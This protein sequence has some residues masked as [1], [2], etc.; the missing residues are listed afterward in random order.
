MKTLLR[1]LKSFWFLILA[2]WAASLVVC[3][4]VAPRV[5]W[6]REQLLETMLIVSTFY[7]LIIVLRQYKRI[8][9]ERNLENLVQIEVDR[10]LKSNGEFRDQQ[11]L[12]DRLKHAIAMLRADRS[13]GG[14]GSSALYDLPWYLVIGMSAAGKTSLLTRSGLSASIAS[15]QNDNDS[16][17]QHCDWYFSP[18]A[19]LIDTAGRYL[20][21]DQSA[22]EFT[23]FLQLL[24]KQRKKAAVNGLVLVVSLP[25]L[26]AAT[27]D[28]RAQM[29][30]QL[31]S[32]IE[33][34]ARCLDANP[35]I[36]LMLSKT[37]QLP[38][39]NQAFDGLDLTERQQPLGMTFGL[40][41]IRSLGLRAVLDSKL[42]NLHNGIQR[43]VDAQMIHLGA[44]ANSTLLNFPNYFAE[45]SGV[46]EQ[47]LEHFTQP[48]SH[49][50][51][52]LL[53]GLYFTSAL[54]TDQQ[55]SQVY[56]DDLAE[57]FALLPGQDPLTVGEASG[58]KVGD[59]SY[60]ITDTFRR[61]IFADRDLTRYQSRTGRDTSLSPAVIALA[62]LAG[63]AF[64]GWQALAFQNNRAWIAALEQK[65]SDLNAAPDRDQR[66]AAGEGLELLRDQLTLIEKHRAKGVPLQLSAGLYRGDDI[67]AAAESAYLQQLRAQA[68]EP[69]ALKLQ[70]QMRT[71]NEFAKSMDPQND[72]P[73]TAGKATG[74]A[75]KGQKLI[76]R[77]VQNLAA[78][79]GKPTLSSIP[80]SAA[81][82]GNRLKGMARG[83]ASK[84]RDG[85]MAD[86]RN[87]AT[88]SDAAELSATTGGLSLSEEMLGRLDEHQVASI[89]ESYNSLKLYLMLTQPGAHPDP[90]F[91]SA[92]LP[93][94]WASTST[95]A[96]PVS[97]QVIQDNAPMYVQLLKNGQAPAL[98][99]NEQLVDSTRK[100][101]KSF[102]ISSSLVD[103][104]YLRLQLESS[105]QFPAIS[106]NDLVPLPGRQLL[107]GSEAVPAIF[108]RQGWDGFVKPELIKLV[109]GNLRN[110][111]DW[112]LDGEGGDSIVQKAN[113][114]R[115]FMARYKRD[116]AQVWY[117]LL[118]GVG[119]RHFTDMA[120]ATEQLSLLSD[121]QN[122][123]VKILLS[124]VND[125]TQW[126]LPAP[127]ETQQP[128]STPQD[129]FWGKVTGL[130]DDP[131]KSSVAM[132]SPLPPV[133]DGSLAKRFEPVSRV[134]AAQNSEGADSTI[135]DRYLAALRKLKVRMN[136]I[137][138]SQDV[139]KSSKQLISETLEGQPSEVTNVRN[140]VETTV[141][142]SQG[143]LSASLQSLFSLPIQ[144]AWETL[145]DPAGQQIAKAWAQQ[146]AKPWEQV[147][148]HRYPIAAGS[149]NE[150][151][152]K[153]LQ[154]FVDPESGLLP[155]FK[156]NEIGNLSGGE[157]LGMSSGA[158]AAPLVN[159]NMVNSIDKA[160]S[161]GE[162]IASLSDKENGFEIM[163]EPSAYFTDIIFTLDGQEQH[164]RNGK[165]SWS[166]FSWPG[167]TTAPGA[168]LDVVTLTGERIT[169][170]DYPGRWGLLRMNDSARVVD[171]DGIQQRFSWTTANGQVSL[172]VRNYGG[173]K[174]TD[175][176]NVKALSALNTPV[177]VADG[178][179]K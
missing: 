75:G 68:L 89:I 17:T 131:Q 56:E 32:R 9:I 44:D 132:L 79:A 10:S 115:E 81:D 175:L 169:V 139:G 8:R 13:A 27:A 114:M 111:S 107:Y 177:S 118:N 163:L 25:E 101:L 168:R 138:R 39:F 1:A 82:A 4:F 58:K 164:Y 2:L 99:R 142:T 86:L 60:F 59:R 40:S 43:H 146:I 113:F 152:V 106:L 37:D 147:M 151:S 30:T 70:M 71:F 74:K 127:R 176:A 170:F 50:S 102:M 45:L 137:Q 72:F 98:P 149:R 174:L 69:V 51:P 6:S 52:L 54:Q 135:M 171:L 29:A 96:S 116:Y 161:L 64:I 16:G 14:G 141:D 148:A 22:S 162:V 150:A 156:R 130:F 62:A 77:G 133:D 53:R 128:G 110:E 5:Q 154:R 136:N 159:P 122:S 91:V 134:F 33:E 104:E 157:G 36:Y 97:D 160:S 117:A 92:A 26:L 103:R 23:A 87:P 42:A 78:N 12:R 172:A 24:K 48:A 140:Y 129:T 31:V 73:A 63:L 34:Y 179:T 153:D 165:T 28:E 178:R 155:N 95:E 167:T 100:S 105:R 46:L 109:S 19:V 119:V 55:L 145:R 123:P 15:S 21:D 18:D 94:A 166:R 125:N 173:V 67:F 124:A 49:G 7:V 90:E 83:A 41:E 88:A 66:M 65:I 84:T 38:G 144:F 108:T 3:G 11:V 20:R 143:N 93:V 80:R 120:N 85:A 76:D 158:K 112:V 57:S 121:V 61:V 126:D 35:P 47:F